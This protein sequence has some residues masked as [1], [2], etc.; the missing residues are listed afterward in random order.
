[1]LVQ[2]IMTKKVV[3]IDCNASVLDA[4]KTYQE[5][6]VGSLVVMDNKIIVGIITERDII[7]RII[8]N[9]KNPVITKVRDIMSQNIKTIHA[10][11]SLDKASLIM[12]ENN[13]KKLPVILNNEI[14]GIVTETDLSRSIQTM[15]EVFDRLVIS[16][17]HNKETIE[18]MMNEWST[19]IS[20]LKNHQKLTRV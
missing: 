3:T 1:M 2:D 8:I 19:I 18:N 7:E 13:I 5:L 16:Y 6:K 14:V 10:L 4:C 12:K 15:S 17:E 9:N 20:S 11:A